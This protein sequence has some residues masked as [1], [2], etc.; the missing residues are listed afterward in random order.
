MRPST[1]NYTCRLTID[2]ND[3]L[4]ESDETNNVHIGDSFFI[5]NE[6]ELWANDVD[7]DGFNTTDSGDGI[8]DDCPTT[9]GESTIDRFGCADIDEDGVSNLN[10]FLAT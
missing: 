2:V 6:E 8:V 4:V 7:R 3:D 5:Q 1:G 10:D 9:F